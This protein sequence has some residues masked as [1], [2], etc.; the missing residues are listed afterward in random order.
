MSRRKIRRITT[1]KVLTNSAFW[2][3]DGRIGR[4]WILY[5]KPTINSNTMFK[6]N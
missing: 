2:E 5:P 1:T 6:I 3:Y 4:I